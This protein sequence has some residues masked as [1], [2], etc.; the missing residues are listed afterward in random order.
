MRLRGRLFSFVGFIVLL[1]LAS[2]ALSVLMVQ[3]RFLREEAAKRRRASLETLA[4][5][6]VESSVTRD[7]L[8]LFNYLKLVERTQPD[9]R[10]LC[11]VTAAGTIQA[12]L[13]PEF[14]GLERGAVAAPGG[15][16]LFERPVAY[17]GL[18]L[19]YVEI[20]FD[21]RAIEGEVR[22]SLRRLMGRLAGF[23]ALAL[24]LGLAFSVLLARSMAR[25]ILQLSQ[26]AADIAEGQDTAS[27]PLGRADELGELA[28][29]FDS[30]RRRLKELDRMKQ[31][32][33]SGTTHELR[34]PLGAIESHTNLLLE[35]LEGR[36]DIPADAL[37]DSTASLGHIKKNCARL[38]AFI[39]TLLD[40]AKIERGK[41][42]IAPRE[43]SLAE[44]IDDAAAHFAPQALE[45][46]LTLLR[47]VPSDL[48]GVHADPER[49]HQVLGNLLGNA[50]KFTPRG[51]EVEI[52][53]KRASP[54]WVRVQVSDTGP[55]IP[56]DFLG[57]IFGKFEQASRAGGQ[58]GTG[59]GLAICKGIVELHGGA[60]GVS[61]RAG[62]GA[63]FHFTLP[64]A[65]AGPG[66]APPDAKGSR[67]E[68]A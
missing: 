1:V 46:G 23:G 22:D 24:G 33:V 27:L 20:G 34:T 18:D 67:R 21:R 64:V 37:E 45:R 39:S 49:I 30:M 63:T 13:D 31:D 36:G 52:S 16:E 56:K 32:F 54:R 48:P 51:G 10:W 43:V 44:I 19:G 7:P 5:L 53:A 66:A 17:G 42:E 2:M 55:G 29:S 6:V 47:R 3:K 8:L 38:G 50:M 41:L 40:Q 68:A 11:V 28:R 12:S 61:S 26:A 60:I 14:F 62:G 57:K 9:V 59:L 15:V 65:G 4:G 35:T 58:G 25:P